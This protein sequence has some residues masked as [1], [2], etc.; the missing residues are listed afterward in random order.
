MLLFYVVK[1]KVLP[2]THPY[3]KSQSGLVLVSCLTNF[4]Y[5]VPIHV[6]VKCVTSESFFHIPWPSCHGNRGK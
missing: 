4:V 5:L 1:L 2:R 6:L 3:E